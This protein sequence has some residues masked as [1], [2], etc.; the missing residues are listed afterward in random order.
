MRLRRRQRRGPVAELVDERSGDLIEDRPRRGG[1][2]KPRPDGSMP[3][4]EPAQ[5]G[6]PAGFSELTRQRFWNDP[7]QRVV[8]QQRPADPGNHRLRLESTTTAISSVSS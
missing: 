6:I 1:R 4:P 8:R 3:Q 5:R 7:L 2:A